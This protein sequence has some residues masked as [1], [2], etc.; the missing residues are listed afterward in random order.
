MTHLPLPW[1]ARTSIVASPNRTPGVGD[2]RWDEWP[3][4]DDPAQPDAD[5]GDYSHA[6]IDPATGAGWSHTD[7]D[8]DAD[9]LHTPDGG[10]R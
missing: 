6:H 4:A 9:Y 2:D 7:P 8:C 3:P 5:P 1:A 10:L